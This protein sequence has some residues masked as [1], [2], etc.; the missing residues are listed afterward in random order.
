MF[1]DTHVKPSIPVRPRK[2]MTNEQIEAIRQLRRVF[3]SD[4]E[5]TRA[6]KQSSANAILA[7]DTKP[8]AMDALLR[9]PD[10]PDSFLALPKLD[11]LLTGYLQRRDG[12]DAGRVTLYGQYVMVP[13]EDPTVLRHSYTH[14]KPELTFSEPTADG[15][16][17]LEL[18]N[19]HLPADR[20]GIQIKARRLALLERL[21]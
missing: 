3:V 18:D 1:C 6:L 20:F 9:F 10:I 12:S 11:T 17:E 4:D 19:G 16:Y 7:P 14:L 21:N 5:I 13:T 8:T 15:Y 2:A